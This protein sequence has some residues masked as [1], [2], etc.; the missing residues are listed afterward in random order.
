[1]ASKRVLCYLKGRKDLELSYTKEADGVKFYGSADADWA[2]DSDDRM[3]TTG[4]SLHLQTAGAA[5]S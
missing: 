2:G 3:S 5:T 4:Y 1:M